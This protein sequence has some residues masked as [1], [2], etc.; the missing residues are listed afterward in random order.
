MKFQ[1]IFNIFLVMRSRKHRIFHI[2]IS[3]SIFVIFAS[4]QI[5]YFYN[6]KTNSKCGALN[7]LLMQIIYA[8][9]HMSI[10]QCKY[11]T[12]IPVLLVALGLLALYLLS[13][14]STI[15]WLLCPCWGKLARYHR[16][17]QIASVHTANDIFAMHIQSC[18]GYFNLSSLLF[19]HKFILG[20]TKTG[21]I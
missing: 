21:S 9:L 17:S 10:V 20:P 18:C 14:F 19:L 11:V 16:K 8:I 2:F 13:T 1:M 15:A 4:S 7:C 6:Y 3:K 12:I 5:S